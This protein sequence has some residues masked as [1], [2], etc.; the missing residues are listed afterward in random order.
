MPNILDIDDALAK[1]VVTVRG[2]ELEVWPISADDLFYLAGKYP[3]VGAMLG[4]PSAAAPMKDPALMAELIACSQRDDKGNTLRGNDKAIAAGRRLTASDQMKVVE[5]IFEI[6]FEDGIVRFVE[7]LAKLTGGTPRE[8][9][10]S[11]SGTASRK[12]S[13]N[14]LQT[15]GPLPLPARFHRVH[16]PS[17]APAPKQ[18][19]AAA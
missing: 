12:I 2:K 14:E 17:N 8:G 19:T 10:G 13:P 15:D 1:S 6:S 5:K 3:V 16:S 9:E 11:A 7:S 18:D 4:A